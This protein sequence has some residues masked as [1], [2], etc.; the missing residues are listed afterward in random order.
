[1]II[2]IDGPSGTG[3]STVA[4]EVA[5][6]LGFVFFD[7]GAMYRCF[8]WKVLQE[9][10]DPSDE[11]Q[12]S[13]LVNLFDFTVK[14]VDGE[15]RYFVGQEDVTKNIR[16]REISSVS[17]QISMYSQVRKA[18][19]KKQ[20]QFAR[21]VNAVFEGRDMGTVV[22]PNA[23]LKIFLTADPVIRAERRY[24]ELIGKFPDF[25]EGLT[26]EEILQE[27][28]KRD[29]NDTTRSIS[30]LKQAPDAILID[31]SEL[32]I[33]DVV[34]KILQLQAQV[35]PIFFRMKTSYWLVYLLAR[36]FFKVFFRLKIHGLKHLRPG[37][38]ILIANH[39]SFYDPPVLSISCPEEVH[40]MARESLFRIP[41]LGRLIHVLNTH[42]VS[43]DAG[44]MAVLKKMVE[45]LQNQ[46]KIIVFP[47]GKRSIDGNI[48]PFQRGF[49]FLAIKAKCPVYPAYLHGVFEA[50]P[51]SRKFPRFFG[52][53]TCTFGSP[54][55]WDEFED[56]PRK[57]AEQLLIEKSL[58]S[59]EN[60]KKWYQGGS[61]GDPP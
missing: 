47:E 59:I 34:D 37:A 35:K 5:K 61:V 53:I 33:F 48:Q 19:V 2:V 20:R 30:P 18:I 31:T 46:K 17:S 41:L 24:Q 23:D 26:K 38:G 25:S 58:Q 21:K 16:S 44:D 45:L 36:F 22:F 40:F 8:A 27:V 43:Q 4:K 51:P 14:D 1:M 60:L 12:V 13:S 11:V 32:S 15:K 29:E 39:T 6:R 57:E 9:K 54:I 55:E 7:T 42:P 56:L 52:K 10:I 28:L 3:K 49:G 50:W